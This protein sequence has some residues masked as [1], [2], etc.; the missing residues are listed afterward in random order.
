M[1][2]SVSCMSCY[3]FAFQCANPISELKA[4]LSDDRLLKLQDTKLSGVYHYIYFDSSGPQITPLAP[5]RVQ[6]VLQIPSAVELGQIPKG[7]NITK[8]VMTLLT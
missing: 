7:S 3:K 2:V 1:K 8:E 5:G 4:I 6:D